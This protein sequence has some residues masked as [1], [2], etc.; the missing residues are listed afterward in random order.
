MLRL[1]HLDACWSEEQIALE[2]ARFYVK[3]ELIF[4]GT[5]Y[6]PRCGGEVVWPV[7]QWLSRIPPALLA[8]VDVS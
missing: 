4:A 2:E 6:C 5:F 1:R 3:C 7:A 8:T